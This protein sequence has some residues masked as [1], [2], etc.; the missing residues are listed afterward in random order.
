MKAVV[1][2]HG[3][4]AVQDVPEPEPGKGQILLNVLR[5]GI[6][7]SDLHARHHAD[8][9]A[10]AMSNLEKNWRLLDF[11][12]AGCQ[13]RIRRQFLVEATAQRCDGLFGELLK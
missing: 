1:C 3:D 6:C 2:H 13:E 5:C 12:V 10:E 9:L 4:F 8:E 7:G 11:D